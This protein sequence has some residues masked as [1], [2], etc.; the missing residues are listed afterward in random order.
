MCYEQP[1]LKN[2]DFDTIVFYGVFAEEIEEYLGSE[3]NWKEG[4]L[5]LINRKFGCDAKRIVI[6]WDYKNP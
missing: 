4:L 5:E 6:I 2:P 3:D 1:N